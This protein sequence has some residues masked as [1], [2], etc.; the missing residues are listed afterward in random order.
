[1]QRI[2][3]L[4]GIFG[5]KSCQIVGMVIYG[6]IIDNIWAI[7]W[8]LPTKCPSNE[9][10]DHL[11]GD[12]GKNW[13]PPKSVDNSQLSLKRGLQSWFFNSQLLNC[14]HSKTNDNS[15]SSVSLITRA[16]A[17]GPRVS[18]NRDTH[19]CPN[20]KL[21]QDRERRAKL[22]ANPGPTRETAT[23]LRG[24]RRRGRERGP[25]TRSRSS[26]RPTMNF[27]E[28]RKKTVKVKWFILEAIVLPQPP[29][30][31]RVADFDHT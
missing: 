17:L 4:W 6:Q 18:R 24:T 13:F 2:D 14:Y 5:E 9:G 12:L 22:S 7:C 20:V 19:P 16:L 21:L 27:S 10:N 26:S 15:P 11:H 31:S 1:M 29:T 3:K 30:H 28:E 8:C 25:A 23:H